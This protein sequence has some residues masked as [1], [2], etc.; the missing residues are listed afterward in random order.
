LFG[1]WDGRLP[2][3]ARD[4]ICMTR[5]APIAAVILGAGQARRWRRGHKLL[6]EV[7]GRPLIAIAADTAIEAGLMPVIVVLGH[8]RWNLRRALADR[9]LNIVENLDYRR[10]MATSLKAGITAVPPNCRAAL[11]LLA[12]MPRVSSQHIR[13]LVACFQSDAGADICVPTYGGRR[14]NPVLWGTRYFAELAALAGDEG[15]RQLFSRYPERIREVEMA[16]DGVL[17]DIDTRDELAR[18][19]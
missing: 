2:W 6:V 7:A 14:G 1:G 19:A 3:L 5:S 17:I 16:D 13:A 9:P 11:V 18:L 12:D 8:G 10:G 15:G 4:Q